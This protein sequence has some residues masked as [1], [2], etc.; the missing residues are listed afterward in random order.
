MARELRCGIDGGDPYMVEDE[1]GTT[2]LLLIICRKDGAVD[3]RLWEETRKSER[4]A[5]IK[6]NQKN[7]IIAVLIHS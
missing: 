1:K 2:E 5:F 6:Y 4:P 7:I 3:P